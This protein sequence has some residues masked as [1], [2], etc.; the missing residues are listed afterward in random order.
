MDAELVD[1]YRV[2]RVENGP[3][4]EC[5]IVLEN[6]GRIVRFAHTREEACQ[7]ALDHLFADFDGDD[8]KE[9]TVKVYKVTPPRFEI[10]TD[11]GDP[12][13]AAN[14]YDAIQWIAQHTES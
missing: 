10:S 9:V 4:W 12:F 14:E 5:R 8:L 13:L 7:E 11:I 1:V 2:S 6:G 3:T